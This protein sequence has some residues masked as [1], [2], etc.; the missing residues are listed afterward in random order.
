MA[1]ARTPGINYEHVLRPKHSGAV[2]GKR[3]KH[4]TQNKRFDAVPQRRV[5]N[6]KNSTSTALQLQRI[7]TV[8]KK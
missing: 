2:R 4:P 3:K 6:A 8:E 1:R 7:Y 5:L